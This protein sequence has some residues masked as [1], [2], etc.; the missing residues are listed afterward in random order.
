MS[1]PFWT[2]LL[3]GG[4][5][6]GGYYVYTNYIAPADGSTSSG[7]SLLS[8]IQAG[9]NRLSSFGSGSTTTAYGG[10][11]NGG[12]SSIPGTG[13]NGSTN[14][15]AEGNSDDDGDDSLSNAA[16]DDGEDD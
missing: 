9:L 7:N 13:S 2:F 10:G 16:E 12:S 8:N 15:P 6:V 14:S 4:A 5:A 3:V 1:K 11:S